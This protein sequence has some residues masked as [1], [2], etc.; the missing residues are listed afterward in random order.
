MD[1]VQKAGDYEPRLHLAISQVVRFLNEEFHRLIEVVMSSDLIDY[2][3]HTHTH[4]LVLFEIHPFEISKALH[5]YA[6]PCP[7]TTLRGPAIE[8]RVKDSAP[9]S[10]SL[11]RCW[12]PQY[13]RLPFRAPHRCFLNKI[14]TACNNHEPAAAVYLLIWMGF[15]AVA[16]WESSALLAGTVISVTKWYMWRGPLRWAAHA[17]FCLSLTRCCTLL[18]ACGT[19]Q[20]PDQVRGFFRL[21]KVTIVG[22]YYLLFT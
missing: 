3:L 22:F 19:K 1:K 9:I 5:Y 17:R 20:S 10:R 14:M 4:R 7:A 13:D 12:A 8:F 16:A 18:P 2:K 21:S 11:K 6:T 15:W